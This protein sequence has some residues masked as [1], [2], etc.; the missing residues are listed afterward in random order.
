MD[1]RV[2]LLLQ[3]YY[4]ILVLRLHSISWGDLIP[5]SDDFVVAI[6]V[7]RHRLRHGAWNRLLLVRD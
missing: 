1:T 3:Y 4:T 7:I 5:V 2:L 6:P